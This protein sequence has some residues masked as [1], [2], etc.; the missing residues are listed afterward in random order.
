MKTILIP[1]HVGFDYLRS[2]HVIPQHRTFTSHPIPQQI[3]HNWK[4]EIEV[5]VKCREFLRS[6]A[7]CVRV[8]SKFLKSMLTKALTQAKTILNIN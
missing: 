7:T 4:S 6:V 1:P 3:H 5:S 8:G 2:T